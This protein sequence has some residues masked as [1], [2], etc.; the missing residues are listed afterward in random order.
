MQLWLTMLL[1]LILAAAT[2]ISRDVRRRRQAAGMP[3]GEV[4]EQ[5]TLP[6]GNN[7]ADAARTLFSRRYG[8]VGKPDYL[9]EDGDYLIPVEVK[10]TRH[11][12][13]PR[14]G[15]AMQLYAYCLLVEEEYGKA[16]PYG[17]LR[18]PDQRFELPYGR[19]ER[20]WVIETLN[21]MREDEASED[22]VLPNHDQPARCRS[23][24][25]LSS[26]GMDVLGE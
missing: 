10:T 2:L 18:Y 16:P 15:H 4:V 22:E 20:A 5:D 6:A 24:Q 26:C 12:T 11:V 7:A 1:I 19:R 3:A 14:D 25:F 21:L 9:V 23:C 13:R 8:L 17:I